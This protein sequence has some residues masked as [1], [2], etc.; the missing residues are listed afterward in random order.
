M[1]Q[2]VLTLVCT[3]SFIRLCCFG[4]FSAAVTNIITK[5]NL[6]EEEVDFKLQVIV[7]HQGSSVGFQR[8]E[9]RNH[10]EKAHT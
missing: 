2:T 3:V 4:F 5:I 1:S 8:L 9:C 10:K 6:G 7:H